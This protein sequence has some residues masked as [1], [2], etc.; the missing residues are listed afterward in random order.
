MLKKE[1]D[2]VDQQKEATIRDIERI[3]ID[4]DN[5]HQEKQFLEREREKILF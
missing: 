4:R 5:L 2:V 3:I 1:F